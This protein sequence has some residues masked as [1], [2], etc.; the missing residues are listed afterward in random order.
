MKLTALHLKCAVMEYYR[1]T[2][3]CLCVD[4][5]DL[6][7]RGRADVLVDTGSQIHEIEVKVS[8]YDLNTLEGKKYKHCAQYQ[9]DK[10]YANKFSLCV[11]N[12]LV[13]TAKT[14]IAQ[15]NPKY[16]LIEYSHGVYN[17]IRI[18]KTAKQ[19]NK[20]YKTVKTRRMYMRLCSSLIGY[21]KKQLRETGNR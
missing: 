12:Y 14:W 4:E 5:V 10:S 17:K 21:M 7:S 19:L 16:G 2:R 15:T 13:D 18:V 3:Q 20:N 9:V 6:G 8:K 1:Y 11:P